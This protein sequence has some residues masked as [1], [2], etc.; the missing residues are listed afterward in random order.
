M[1][2]YGNVGRVAC[3]WNRVR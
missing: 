2:T 3:D 1:F